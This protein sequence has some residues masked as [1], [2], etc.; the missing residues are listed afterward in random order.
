MACECEPVVDQYN[1]GW[2]CDEC[3]NRPRLGW[4][5]LIKEILFTVALITGAFLCL[6]QR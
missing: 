5:A 3:A 2:I 1:P 4:I 6:V